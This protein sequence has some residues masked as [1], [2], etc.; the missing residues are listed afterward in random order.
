MDDLSLNPRAAVAPPLSR[1]FISA[2]DAAVYAHETVGKKRDS[3]YASC[4][5]KRDDG[6][7]VVSEPVRADEMVDVR[8]LYPVGLRGQHLFPA[9]HTLCGIFYSHVAL[10]MLDLQQV[11]ERGWTL[12]DATE[13]LLMF[14]VQ[15]LRF[16]L[17]QTVPA[18]LS[19]N[20]YNL[21]K[22]EPGSAK[23]KSIQ[24]EL[25]TSKRPGPLAVGLESGA[26][27]PA[28]LR[29]ELEL[30]DVL[31]TLLD[32]QL[33]KGR[34]VLPQACFGAIYGSAQDAAQDRYLRPLES[35]DRD[36]V[37]FGFILKRR[38]KE[39]YIASELVRVNLVRD[40]LFKLRSLF[41]ASGIA[42][43]YRLPDSF[44]M[45][46]YFYSRPRVRHVKGT[47][48]NWLAE[49]FI[50]PKDLFVAV[51]YAGKY[52]QAETKQPTSV[53][54]STH[55]GALLKYTPDR[56]TR[57]FNNDWPLMGLDT[58]QTYLASGKMTSVD[59]VR[60]VA[61]HGEL[62]VLRTS[63][64]WDREGRVDKQWWMP[65]ANLQ[66][67]SLG[68]VFL[69]ADDAAIHAR[70][71]I[72]AG[73]SGSY[74]GLILK[75]ADGCFVATRPIAV[76]QE[77]FDLDFVFPDA[78]VTQ[79]LFPAGC[80]IV[81][82][83]RSRVA[84]ELPILMT[85]VN[86][87]IYSNMLSTQVTYTAV[88]RRLERP[89]RLEEYLFCPDGAM[90]RYLVGIG[91]SIWA[92]LVAALDASSP[93]ELD[94]QWVRQ[95]IH[96]GKLTPLEWV[97]QLLKRGYLT[98][99]I[100]SKLWGAPRVLSSF[101]PHPEVDPAQLGRSSALSEPALSPLF[102]DSQGAARFAHE[103]LDRSDSLKCGVILFNAR[104]RTYLSSQP[105]KVVN[106]ALSLEQ[107]FPSGNLP[108]RHT[109][110]AVFL[111]APSVTD[112]LDDQD[113]RHFLSPM[114]VHYAWKLAKTPQGVRPIYFSCN[115]GALLRLKLAP[116][117]PDAPVD[118]F[119]QI[120]LKPN[121]FASSSE[122]RAELKAINE[123]RFKLQ[124]YV[125]SM[126]R[127]GDLQVLVPGTFWSRRG[128]V[129]DDW[130]PRMANVSLEALWKDNQQLALGPIF[131][132]ADDAARYAQLRAGLLHA[133]SSVY[134]SAILGDA[135]NNAYVAIEPLAEDA[136][137]QTFKRIF[138]THK[139]AVGNPRDKPP[140][141]PDDYKIVGAQQVY[142]WPDELGL[143]D[144]EQVEENFASKGSVH[145][146]TFGLKAKGF[147]IQAYYYSTPQG[148][149]LKYIPGYSEAERNL[150]RAKEAEVVDGQWV[151]QITPGSFI[152]QL[153]KLAELRVLKAAGYWRREGRIGGDWRTARQQPRLKA[154]KT[155]RDEL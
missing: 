147:E 102:T 144:P 139:K 45:H 52:P 97:R 55:D 38:G 7:F 124:S 2:D 53:F 142:S 79:G 46:S 109:F 61:A 94:G 78:S 123:G 6:R 99:V 23:L 75:R 30:Q 80:T 154:Q 98:V 72:P 33:D 137:S 117:D 20:E 84:R 21:I 28:E 111:S 81:G 136:D 8:L 31:Q 88:T 66:R 121:S 51:Y 42:G 13:S 91:D 11:A 37:W 25:G 29:R 59:F 18:Y 128:K 118:K 1:V 105:R 15:E 92:E 14:S 68:P 133:Q 100:G 69:T 85:R 32:E 65:S 125:R 110:D 138:R 19:G 140:K 93:H 95:Q 107:L 12:A 132:H 74:G 134:E 86:K 146:H 64:Y 39:E 103:R 44:E 152:T 26:S 50:V 47:S 120:Q 77:D 71:E 27:K 116:F 34:Q 83:Y 41:P 3:R 129:G 141:Y 87:E 43:G 22:L 115:D 101:D 126:S 67:L 148:A 108:Y 40:D 70:A 153:A 17:G 63:L 113:Y 96:E 135:N 149:L 9:K 36:H 127:Y 48:K 90:I 122:A 130:Q 60:V 114:D 143:L 131:H 119:G 104:T 73:A 151:T 49:H 5:F 106:S 10:S 56:N 82:R 35:H 89:E 24:T 145:A 62:E 150:F 76:F 58:I 54:I 112:T 57:L 16:V 4:V 155:V